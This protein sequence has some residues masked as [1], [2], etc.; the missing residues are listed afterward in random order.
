M[1]SISPL[2]LAF[3]L[4][5]ASAIEL[6]NLGTADD[7]AILSKSGVT[8]TGVTSVTGDI[9][10][11][12]IAATA[13]T[14]FSLILDSSTTF[15]TSPD[16]VT[17]KLYAASYTS[18]TPSK[19]TTAISDM[20]IAYT[21]AA[22][23]TTPDEIELG[24]GNIENHILVPGLYKW[25]T[26]VGFTSSLTFNG[27]NASEE[28]SN[29]PTSYPIYSPSRAPSQMQSFEPSQTPSEELSSVPS[30]SPSDAVWILQISGDL[31]VGSGAIVTLVGGAKSE[32]I[33]WQI[34]GSTTLK[35]TSDMK[36]IILCAT[37]I[38][39][40]TGS[41]LVG[42]ALAQTAVTLDAATIVKPTSA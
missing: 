19:L 20:E 13:M 11:S 35:T 17:G 9:G 30:S 28:T 8:T 15:S 4:F 12:P 26:S 1:L 24:A 39:F 38:V 22:G 37:N 32:N 23:R 5:S 42:A 21:D 6:V 29:E 14:G 18:P 10:T 2:L 33:F 27:T 34:A 25:G 31:T 36:G 7:F 16:I 41:S 40:Q 3:N